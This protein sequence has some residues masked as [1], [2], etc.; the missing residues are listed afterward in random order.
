M[1][2]N[3]G[4]MGQVHEECVHISHLCAVRNRLLTRRSF[5]RSVE[6]LAEMAAI[7]LGLPRE[8]FREAGRY[9][10]ITLLF[11]ESVTHF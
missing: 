10:Y 11:I 3:Y 7:G 1:D 9:G 2:A 6:N 8:T 5:L 4:E